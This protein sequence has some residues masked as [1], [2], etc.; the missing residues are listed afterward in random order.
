MSGILDFLP[1]RE[2]FKHK[3]GNEWGGPCPW[4]G[5]ED[6]FVVW[7]DAGQDGKGSF[8]CRQCEEKGFATDFLE[9][10]HNMSPQKAHEAL[11]VAF[12]GSR[13]VQTKG[14]TSS[15][16]E[17]KPAAIMPV[18]AGAAELR[19]G[20]AS[21][22]W[23]YQDIAGRLLGY[24]ARFT[25][26]ENDANGKPRKEFRPY[27][28]TGNGWRCQGFTEPKP[29]YGLQKLFGIPAGGSVL[30]VEGEG[31]ADALQSVL[32]P[33]VAVLGLHG[34]CKGVWKL[35]F[36][37]LTGRKLVYWPDADAPGAGA[38][39]AVAEAAGRAG[40]ESTRIVVP[41]EGVPQ[42]WDGADAVRQGWDRERL[43]ELI[44]AAV[45][46]AEFA[47]TAAG[48]W[49]VGKP[50]AFPSP[51]PEKSAPPLRVV[52]IRELLSL[53]I[54]PRGHVLFP[55]IPEQGLVMLFADRGTGKTFVGFHVAYAVASGGHVFRW[56]ADKPRRVLYLD[57]EMPLA[58][59]QQRFADLV[60]VADTEPDD[61]FLRIVTPD[62]Q[63]D[64]L[65][66]NLATE[67]GQARLEPYLAG[68]ELVVVDNL[69]TLARTGRS[70]DEDHWLPVQEWILRL[71]RRG[72]SV[73]LIHH[74]SKNGSQRGTAAKE[75][76]LDTVIRL[77]RPR[78]YEAEQGA[79]FEVTLTKARGLC[80]EDAEPFEAALVNGCQW[81]VRSVEDAL[82]DQVRAL[83]ADGLTMRELAEE[84]GRSKS[85]IA[86][87][88]KKKGIST[89]GQHD[90][91]RQ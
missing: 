66:P 4:C 78:D 55:V 50:D 37:P 71:R 39:L 80:G 90:R 22:V 7:A 63:G 73:L 54:P 53:D 8:L 76:V 12:N 77:T 64:F 46:P 45:A 33:N 42:G 41:P 56:H 14:K 19:L 28:Y 10:F 88:C 17:S 26:P 32:G 65:M 18:P 61:D 70:N 20:K 44:K 11:G 67:E 79:R 23:S 72:M 1:N 86:R 57:G 34:G 85:T 9:K 83:A 69:A 49:D 58:A 81:T 48:R 84:T 91:I 31:K 29:L 51:L 75:D 2:A 60:A 82:S 35:D 21:A 47:K 87:L 40:A 16:D 89:R 6:R 3:T 52:N 24:V 30:L 13:P 27:V 62:L 36:A 25:K 5:G 15:K 38:A 74:A 59:V 43:V 68:V